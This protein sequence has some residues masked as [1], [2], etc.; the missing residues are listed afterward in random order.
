MF[1]EVVW[2][3]LKLPHAKRLTLQTHTARP[4]V[5]TQTQPTADAPRSSH[6]PG[7]SGPV[8]IGP[9]QSGPGQRL[10]FL[11]FIVPPP[12]TQN[13]RGKTNMPPNPSHRTPCLH[14]ARLLCPQT[15]SLPSGPP[16]AFALTIQRPVPLPPFGSP[17]N[18]AMVAELLAAAKALNTQPVLL[19]AACFHR[20]ATARGACVKKN[21]PGTLRHW[22]EV[23]ICWPTLS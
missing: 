16:E 3:M 2:P 15:S 23:E 18:A 10:P 7:E 4:R 6:Q 11:S 20:A 13:Q 12:P 22:L 5:T 14:P 1:L 9:K 21:F 17:P 8:A 19:W